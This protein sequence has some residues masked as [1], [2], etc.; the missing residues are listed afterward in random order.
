MTCIAPL[1]LRMHG[2]NGRRTNGILKS[3]G[4]SHGVYL[5]TARKGDIFFP[6][7]FDGPRIHFTWAGSQALQALTWYYM[8]K[9]YVE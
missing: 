6:S 1:L 8:D 4:A 3:L 9:I 7:T 5:A 2:P